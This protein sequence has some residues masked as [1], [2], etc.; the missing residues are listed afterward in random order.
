LENVKYTELLQE[1]DHSRKIKYDK[2]I[3]NL[4]RHAVT[5]FRGLE[6]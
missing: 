5:N 2:N 1:R 4:S 3:I 6:I